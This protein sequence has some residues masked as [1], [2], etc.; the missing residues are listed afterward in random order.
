MPRAKWRFGLITDLIT[1]RHHIVRGCWLRVS[2]SQG[3]IEYLKRPVN[4]LC[5]FEVRSN[6]E[7][8]QKQNVQEKNTRP[9]RLAAFTGDL[10]RN[11]ARMS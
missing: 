10:I 9:K 3:R 8:S 4:K 2:D 5:H 1:S 11:L 7:S 6:A